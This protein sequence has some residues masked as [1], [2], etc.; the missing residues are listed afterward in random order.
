MTGKV[1]STCGRI[2]CAAHKRKSWADHGDR[3]HRLPADWKRRREV[4][5][6]RDP[7]C[8][9]CFAAPATEVDHVERGDDHRLANL[10]GVCRP[11]HARKTSAEANAAQHGQADDRRG[12]TD[13]LETGDG[14]DRKSVV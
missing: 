3:R 5:L 14:T 10:Q 9:I 7:T 6:S 8:R 4:V 13:P 1:C 12:G 2:G 11:C